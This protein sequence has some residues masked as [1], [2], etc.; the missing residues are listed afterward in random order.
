M[1]QQDSI[2][3]SGSSRCGLWKSKANCVQQ[4]NY[5]INRTINIH[6]TSSK[7]I[8]LTSINLWHT[9]ELQWFSQRTSEPLDGSA[10]TPA[11]GFG[12]PSSC[13]VST[14]FNVQVHQESSGISIWTSGLPSFN[15]HLIIIYS[16]SSASENMLLDPVYI[17]FSVL[18]TPTDPNLLGPRNSRGALHPKSTWAR[19]GPSLRSPLP[20]RLGDR[21]S[22][23]PPINYRNYIPHK[24]LVKPLVNHW[25]KSRSIVISCY[26]YS[27]I[28]SQSMCHRS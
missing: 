13:L 28:P 16:I 23:G 15:H 1:N 18:E 24:P 6:Q 27:Y 17:V 25:K 4:C 14:C 19:R 26:N 11:A 2:W 20:R 5:H 10:W 12:H 9:S 3:Q 8:Q 22:V 7:S 21:P